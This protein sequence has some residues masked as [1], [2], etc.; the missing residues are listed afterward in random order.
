MIRMLCGGSTVSEASQ[1]CTQRGAHGIRLWEALYYKDLGSYSGR[2]ERLVDAFKQRH[3][4]VSFQDPTSS[5]L[6]AISGCKLVV[7]LPTQDS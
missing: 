1:E 3:D 7:D 6:F 2:D 5:E 4:L